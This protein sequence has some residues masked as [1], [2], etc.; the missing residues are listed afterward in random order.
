MDRFRHHNRNS[1][2]IIYGLLAILLTLWVGGAV[3]HYCLDGLE[4]TVTVHFDNLN[5]HVEHDAASG[6]DDFEKSAMAENLLSKF[7]EMEFQPFL[8]ILF[9]MALAFIRGGNIYWK[10]LVH[11]FSSPQFLQPPLRAPPFYA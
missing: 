9:V 1:T 5:G 10:E 4:P 2:A 6:H 7:F 3:S 11:E 8:V